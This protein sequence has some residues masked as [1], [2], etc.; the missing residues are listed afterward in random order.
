MQNFLSLYKIRFGYSI[1]YHPQSNPVERVH[2]YLG[3][4]LRIAL[5]QSGAIHDSWDEVVTFPSHLLRV[6]LV[7]GGSLCATVR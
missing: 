7:G 2:R 1:P 6:R 3:A 4:L 5:G